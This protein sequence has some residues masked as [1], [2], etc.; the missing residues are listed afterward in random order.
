MLQSRY[1]HT[2]RGPEDQAYCHCSRLIPL[3]RFEALNLLD[4]APSTY[5]FHRITTFYSRHINNSS[6]KVSK[7]ALTTLRRTQRPRSLSPEP[8][9]FAPTMADVWNCCE[10]QAANHDANSPDRCPLCEHPRCASCSRGPLS[11]LPSQRYSHVTHGASD[12]ILP[13]YSHGCGG[14]GL[15]SYAR[16]S[17]RGWWKCG[18]CEQTNN[19]DL[20]PEKC[21]F[22]GHTKCTCCYVYPQ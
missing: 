3:F 13:G 2:Q 10:C 15:V 1:I 19:P 7:P 18:G 22:C 11:G 5:P 16:P 9:P 21:V 6:L 4:S 12:Y 14:P 8:H 20:A 17:T